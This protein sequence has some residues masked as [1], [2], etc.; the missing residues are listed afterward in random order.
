V[1][2]VK[3]SHRSFRR[4]RA[5]TILVLAVPF[6][7]GQP[8]AGQAG[9]PAGPVPVERLAA[10][11]A[12]LIAKLDGG[13]AVLRSGSQRSIEGD[14]PQDS[15]YRE[16]N[17]FFYL[18]GIEEPDAWLVLDARAAAGAQA[19]L[20]LQPR[21]PQTEQWTGVR[22]G[23]GREATALSGVSDVRSAE[24]AEAEIGALVRQ[25]AAASRPVFAEYG[26]AESAACRGAVK[27]GRGCAPALDAVGTDASLAS[28]PVERITAAL[29]VVKDEEEVRRLRRTIEITTEAHRAA[30]AAIRPGM[31]EYELE[32]EIEYTFRKNG[33]ERVGFPSIIGSGPNS[34]TLHYDRNRRRMEAG[35]LVVID[36]GAEWG[37]YSADVTR[38][39]PV[40]G[41]YTDRQRAIYGLVLGAQ[42]AALDLVKPGATI[43]ELTRAARDYID[44]NSGG[45]CGGGSCDRYFVHGLSH[46]LGM[47][48]HD[49]GEYAV[50][51]QPGMVFTI[52]PGIYIADEQL[53]VRIED[54]VLVTPTGYEL[55]SAGAPRTAADVEKLIAESRARR[56][57]Q[58]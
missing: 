37:Y 56:V 12:A 50:P 23:P 33:A 34:T 44:A 45:L 53:G 42:Q 26:S 38:T 27:R 22:L 2:K 18:T 24:A 1:S 51:L 46:W 3:R 6:P 47:D 52:E 7:F 55:L 39:L 21:D 30:A 36:I 49:V 15:D 32:A 54:D 41:R 13:L 20:Y 10:R 58:D 35:D 14:Y 8:V 17:D 5:T 31:Y 48:V 9:S 16:T 29:R 28:Q 11:R 25:A 4:F 43:A 19:R 40:S 57:T